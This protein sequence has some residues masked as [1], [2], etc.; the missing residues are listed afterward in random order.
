[1]SLIQQNKVV[2]V[3]PTT[4]VASSIYFVR[5]GSGFDLYVTNDTGTIIAY[6]A[7][8]VPLSALSS[9]LDLAAFFTNTLISGTT[10]SATIDVA[11]NPSASSTQVVI[12]NRTQINHNSS[13]PM[14]VGGWL[15]ADQSVVNTSGTGTIDKVV[16]H[17]SQVN[18]TG[19]NISSVLCYEAVISTLAAST[20]VGSFCGFYFP[21]L[22]GV[23][24]I[25]PNIS[26]FAAF[27]NQDSR[28]IIQNM[29]VYLDSDLKQVVAPC[30]PG[31]VA[32]RYYMAPY[33]VIAAANTVVGRWDASPVYVP[34]RTT[35]TKLGMG[36]STANATTKARIGLYTSTS[37]MIGTLKASTA[38]LTL[39]ATGELEGAV[40]VT[41][42]G[43]MYWLLVQTSAIASIFYHTPQDTGT[44]AAMYGQSSGLLSDTATLRTAYV[45]VGSY[46]TFPATANIVPTY[47]A[48]DA[49]P[50]LWFR[51]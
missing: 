35:I 30:H 44:R 11:S 6:S 3:L 37:G 22:S 33:R 26:T 47:A 45:N 8:Y 34:A 48:S 38:E 10:A 15:T 32:G 43:G 42:D 7:N 28:A 31:I 19:G 40:N 12:G 49:E 5:T 4:L 50:H 24:N 39:S 41:V 13:N 25:T 2:S 27:A 46:T 1:M 18:L 29:G 14:A 20:L 17:M 16:S 9:K 21:N 51:A 23:L 36:V